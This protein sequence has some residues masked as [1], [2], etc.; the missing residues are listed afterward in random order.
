MR[1]Q[2]LHKQEQHEISQVM[3]THSHPPKN[4]VSFIERPNRMKC[5]PMA[6]KGRERKEELSRTDRSYCMEPGAS[7]NFIDVKA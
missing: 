5:G 7:N 1:S 6:L 3:S 4:L 2:V